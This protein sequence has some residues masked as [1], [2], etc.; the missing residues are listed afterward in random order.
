MKYWF[1]AL[2]ILFVLWFLMAPEKTVEYV[3]P[4]REKRYGS[5]GP[6]WGP[7]NSFAQ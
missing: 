4:E 2:L 1:L 6:L 3:E 7:R 5:E